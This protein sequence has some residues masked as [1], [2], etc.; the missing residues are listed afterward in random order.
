MAFDPRKDEKINKLERNLYARDAA[1]VTSNERPELSAHEKMVQYGWK[2]EEKPFSDSVV[3]LK[4]SEQTSW[5]TGSLATKVFLASVLFFV[6]AAGIAAYIILGGFNVISSKNVDISIR[7]LTS[8]AAGEET[9][10][11]ILVKNN[12]NSAI[13]SGEVYVEYP[14]GTRQ[15]TDLTKPLIRDQ[16]EIESVNS[17]GI[18][19]ATVKPVFFGEK[20]SVKQV[21][22]SVNYKGRGSNASFAKEKT[23]DIT[24]KSSPILMTVDVPTEVNAGQDIELKVEVTSNSNTLIND[25]IVRA[26][27]PFGFSFTSATPAPTFDTNVWRIGDLSPKSKHTITVRGRMEGQNEEERTFRFTT[28]TVSTTDEKQ[29]AVSYITAQQSL[30]IKKPFVGLSL[31]LNGENEGTTVSVGDQVQGSLRWVNNLSVAVNDVSIQVKLSGRGLDRTRVSGGLGGFYRSVDNTINWDKNSMSQLRSVEPGESGTI[32]FNFGILPGSQQL[33]SQGRNLDVTVDAKVVANRV[34][35]GAPQE[36]RSQTSSVAKVGT[37]LAV[38]ARSLYSIG[39]FKNTGTIPPRAERETTYTI[40]LSASNSFNDASDVVLTTQLPPYVRWLSKFNPQTEQ[41]AYND[42]NRTVTWT[43]P[44]LR[45]GVGYTSASKE[46]SFQVA[47][48]PSLG[49]VGTVPELTGA[50]SVTG[51]DRFTGESLSGS[52]PAVTTRISSDPVFRDGDDMVT[53]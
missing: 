18:Y 35:S 53:P 6:I 37:S 23:F 1:P 49:Q 14:D 44:D 19:T 27:Y 33:I 30:A 32:N 21:K 28:G 15:A 50:I 17:G 47:I 51:K 31:L 20:D 42:S 40:V 13:E 38:N 5:K 45:A 52:K 26:E 34:Q 3:E 29:I 46:V 10:F 43:M 41:I 2:Q 39:A 16:F 9:S 11:D 25:L 8:V 22:V 7:G 24:I 12:N 36:I 48:L 4:E